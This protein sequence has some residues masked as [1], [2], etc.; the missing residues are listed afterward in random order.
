MS[1]ST[2]AVEAARLTEAATTPVW[3][4]RI[5]STRA[6]HP[7]QCSPA[8]GKVRFTYLPFDILFDFFYR[9][10]RARNIRKTPFVSFRYKD[11]DKKGGRR[12]II[13]DT[14]YKISERPADYTLSSGLRRFS[15]IFRKWLGVS[16]VTFLN[17]ALKWAVLE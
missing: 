2:A 5:F 1:Y 10:G 15:P 14:I 9:Q 4:L 12:Y 13:P 7:A 8:R 3:A 6:A 16:P 11:R 17:W